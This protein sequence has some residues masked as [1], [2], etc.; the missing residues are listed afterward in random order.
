[1]RFLQQIPN[2]QMAI[3]EQE[4]VRC[5]CDKAEIL[6]CNE[7]PEGDCGTCERIATEAPTLRWITI[8]VM[9]AMT[10]T[11]TRECDIEWGKKKKIN[12]EVCFERISS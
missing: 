5:N 10:I 4:S 3:H 7:K 1:M 6:F 12:W 11:V 8:L 2:C 9:Q